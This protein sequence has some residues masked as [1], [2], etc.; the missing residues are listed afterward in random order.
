M[1]RSLEDF[2]R[3]VHER[4]LNRGHLSLCNDIFLHQVS[5]KRHAHREQPNESCM[6][7]QPELYDMVSGTFLSC[8]DMCRLGRLKL[9]HQKKYLG[10]RTNFQ[11]S[12]G[13]VHHHLHDKRCLNDHEH[14]TIQ[15]SIKTHGRRTNV[16]A[17]AAAYSP[18]F[19]A[20]MA[21]VILEECEIKEPPIDI[22][23]ATGEQDRPEP[24]PADEPSPKRQG[25][26]IQ[27][28]PRPAD[29]E[30]DARGYGKS[31]TWTQVIRRCNVA[32]PRVGNFNVRPGDSMFPLFQLM[33]PELELK[34]AILCR[35]T[36]RF[37][38]GN[39][40]QG[41]EM[42]WRKTVLV[43]METGEIV[44]KGPPENWKVLPRLKQTRRAGSARMSITSFGVLKPNLV[45]VNLQTSNA[46][47][48]RVVVDVGALKEYWVVI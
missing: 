36:E 44:D 18:A 2:D 15:G 22:F 40:A 24:A 12:C 31:P 35:G 6:T 5:R 21:R 48:V 23:V 30:Y 29:L 1:S 25:H 4:R 33:V 17:Y 47:G 11:T 32:V 46:W 37:K 41:E 42:P 9:P 43:D 10:T 38:P 28:P 14:E 20:Y 19:G 34:L 16:S 13:Y 8:L 3:I 26:G 27:G 39:L 45:F 7:N